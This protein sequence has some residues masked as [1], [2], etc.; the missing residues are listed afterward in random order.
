[1]YG[2][3]EYESVWQILTARDWNLQDAALEDATRQARA[4]VDASC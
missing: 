2:I 4:I 1:V 3:E